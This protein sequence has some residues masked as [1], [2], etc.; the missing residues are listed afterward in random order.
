MSKTLTNYAPVMLSVVRIVAALIFMAHGTQ[1]LLN[2]P[3][4]DMNP[5]LFSM[6]G[7]AGL[8]ELV[9]G[10]LLVIGLFTRPVAFVM[11]GLMAC[12]YFIAHAPQS[13]FPALNG[14]D[15]AILYC[16]FFLYLVFSGPGPIS[17]DALR[18]R[19]NGVTA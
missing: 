18:S 7:I 5:P 15:A 12:A 19:P 1:K 9:G 2:F 16:F 10:A 11:S 6:F 17:V 14:G 13:F 3:A 8:L 4:S